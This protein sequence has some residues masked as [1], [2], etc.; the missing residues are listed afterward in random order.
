MKTHG[1]LPVQF[2]VT[3]VTLET[4]LSPTYLR[5][6]KSGRGYTKQCHFGLGK[7]VKTTERKIKPLTMPPTNEPP[8]REPPIET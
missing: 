6:L 2:D 7:I 4:I 5:I 3:L 8:L 1:M